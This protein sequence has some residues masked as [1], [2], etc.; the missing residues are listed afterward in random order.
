MER[1]HR[2]KSP[3]NSSV[4]TAGKSMQAA[5][6]TAVIRAGPRIQVQVHVPSCWKKKHVVLNQEHGE[7]DQLQ[8]EKICFHFK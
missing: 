4:R 6:G 2:V 8:A 3:R 1:C 5:Y 7:A